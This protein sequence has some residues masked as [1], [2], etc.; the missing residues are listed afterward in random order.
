MQL[1]EL[2]MN[3]FK[4]YYELRCDS[5]NILCTGHSKQPEY[6]NLKMWIESIIKENK[7][8]VYLIKYES[9]YVGYIHIDF[10]NTAVEIGYSVKKKYSKR[11][12]CTTAVQMCIELIQEKYIDIEKIVAWIAEFNKYSAKCVLKNNFVKSTEVKNLFYEGFGKEF[13]MHKYVYITKNAREFKN[14]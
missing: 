9:E 11:G 6:S 1:E 5:N 14:V 8:K 12:I 2:T 13:T 10:K 3:K 4:Y 7:K